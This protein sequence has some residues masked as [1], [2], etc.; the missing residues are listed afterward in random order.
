MTNKALLYSQFNR[1]VEFGTTVSQTNGA[2]ANVP[3]FTPQV[4][5]WAAPKVHSIGQQYKN[6]GTDLQDTITLIIKHNS[7]INEMLQAQYQGKIYDILTISPDDSNNVVVY[8]YIILKLS[9]K[10]GGTE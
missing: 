6:Y 3:T 1:R 8:D 2:G 5:V 7:N 10:V 4:T 9:T